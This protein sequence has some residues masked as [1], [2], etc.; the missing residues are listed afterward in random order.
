MILTYDLWREQFGGD[1]GILG[2][3]I[4][5]EWV[6]LYSHRRDAAVVPHA[7]GARRW[8]P[9]AIQIARLPLEPWSRLPS[10]RSGW[11]SRWAT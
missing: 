11:P 6:S 8:P 2:K 1:P 9:L 4:S 5:A 7:F 10:R 3:T